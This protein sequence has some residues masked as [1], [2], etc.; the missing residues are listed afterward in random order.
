MNNLVKIENNEIV[1][2][3][4]TIEKIKNFEKMKVE[5]DLMQKELKQQLKDKMDSLGIKKFIANGL[6]ATIKSA[7]TRTTLDGKKLKEELPGIYEEYTKVSD[8]ASSITLT[9]AD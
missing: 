7:T 8:V 4:E 9:I 6:C 5:M 1:I 2:A 3:N